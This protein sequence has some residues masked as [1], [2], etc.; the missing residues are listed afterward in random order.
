MGPNE[1]HYGLCEALAVKRERVSPLILK[2]Q[3]ACASGLGSLN[4]LRL[5]E[6]EPSPPPNPTLGCLPQRNQCDRCNQSW[7]RPLAVAVGCGA[8]DWPRPSVNQLATSSPERRNVYA[9]KQEGNKVRGGSFLHSGSFFSFGP[10][11]CFTVR[12]NENVARCFLLEGK[13]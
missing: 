2:S 12:M 7:P 11:A 9:A 4:C 6:A 1:W 5:D 10:F 13:C 3:L 8:P